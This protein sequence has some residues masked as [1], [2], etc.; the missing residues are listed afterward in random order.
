MS[1]LAAVAALAMAQ[2][3]EISH[4]QYTKVSPRYGFSFEARIEI[5]PDGKGTRFNVYYQAQLEDF[6]QFA[7]KTYLHLFQILNTKWNIDHPKLAGNQAIDV[8]LCTG[9]K[10]GGEQRLDQEGSLGNWRKVNTIY[11]FQAQKLDPNSDEAFRELAHEYG[12]AVLPGVSGF[13]APEDWGNGYLGEALF[14]LHAPNDAFSST[15]LRQGY[16]RPRLN[17]IESVRQNGPNSKALS[18]KGKSAMDSYIA[19]LLYSSIILPEPI[20]AR[21]LGAGAGA[22]GKHVP[23]LIVNAVDSAQTVELRLGGKPGWVPI[24]AGARLKGA[25]VITKSGNWAKIKPNSERVW[26]ENGT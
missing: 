3:G 17:D 11:I 22:T 10:A 13:D 19:L 23:G 24:P 25:T 4:K 14:A 16:L 8:Y 6:A 15:T 7:A 21:A 12:H 20:F 5:K 18:T 1:L 2:S 26:L 9:G